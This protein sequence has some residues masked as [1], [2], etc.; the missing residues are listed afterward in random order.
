MRRRNCATLRV[1]EGFAV[2]VFA[3]D[4]GNPRMMAVAEDGTVYVTRPESN[5]V[6]ALRDQDRDGKADG[7]PRV[8]ARSAWTLCTASHYRAA[9]SISPRSTRSTR[10][11]SPT[12][13]P[14]RSSMR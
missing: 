2:S 1:P 7:E 10:A 14:S 11:G 6:A 12:T 8:V 13:A 5:D 4:L 3:E 9:G